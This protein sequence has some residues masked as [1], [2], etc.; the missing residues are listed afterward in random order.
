MDAF[1]AFAHGSPFGL[2]ARSAATLFGVAARIREEH[3][4]PS[5]PAD[6][7]EQERFLDYAKRTLGE[8]ELKLALEE[9]RAM[10]TEQAVAFAR[11]L[12]CQ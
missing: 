6:R 12:G 4:T 8:E 11:G 7:D 5:F 2:D 1:E 10:T 9:G 3:G